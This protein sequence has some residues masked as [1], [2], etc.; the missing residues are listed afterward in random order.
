[1]EL[2]IATRNK[3]KLKEIQA[4]LG[5]SANLISLDKIPNA[6]KV[7]ETGKTYKA[8]ALKKA[9]IIFRKTSL[10]T[11]AEDSG[12]EVKALRNKPGIYSARYAGP[13]ADSKLNNKKLLKALDG[14]PLNRRQAQYRCVAVFINK[15]GRIKTAEAVCKGIIALAPTGGK[16]FGYDPLFIPRGFDKTFGELAEKIKNRISHRAKAIRKLRI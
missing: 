3:G 14:I 7:K 9:R 6:P 1:M 12:L 4:I 16:G 5:K 11:L 13:N 15:H 2:I 10:P 8:N